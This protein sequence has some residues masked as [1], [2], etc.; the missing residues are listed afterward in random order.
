MSLRIKTDTIDGLQITSQQLQPRRALKLAA[1]LAKYLVPAFAGMK[2]D[3]EVNLAA[4]TPALMGML[5]DLDDAALDTLLLQTFASTF[6]IADVTDDKGKTTRK[7]YELTSFE[8]ID[9]AFEGKL[10]TMMSCFKFALEV[11]FSDFFDASG[12]SAA[13]SPEPSK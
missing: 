3:D 9:A 7:K 6:V 12:A 2:P 11:N 10:G 4:L 8:A 1:K 13:P 5:Q